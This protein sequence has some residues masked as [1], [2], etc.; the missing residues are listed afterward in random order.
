MR[1]EENQDRVLYRAS[2]LL[3]LIDGSI[4]TNAGVH[5]C[6]VRFAESEPMFK[7]HFPNSPVVPGVIMIEGLVSLVE[8]ATQTRQTLSHIVEAKFRSVAHPN[9]ELSYIMTPMTEGWRAEVKIGDREVL[10]A[11]LRLTTSDAESSGP[12]ASR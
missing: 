8:R 9:D 5:S 3:G 12:F 6:R 11:R 7:G 2:R 4:S 1:V 10:N